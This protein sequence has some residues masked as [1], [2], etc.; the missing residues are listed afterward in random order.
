MKKSFLIAILVFTAMGFAQPQIR[1]VSPLLK[2]ILFTSGSSTEY[3]IWISF[4][5]K[6]EALNKV[7]QNEFL[8]E[9]SI[10]RR[11]KVA[12][13]G[14]L[15]DFT[16]YPVNGAYINA[17]ENTGARIKNKSK[18]LNSVSAYA[19]IN[20]IVKLSR[21][22][23]VKEMDIVAT[24]RRQ[25]LP[26]LSNENPGI[27]EEINTSLE[28]NYGSSFSQNMQ[29]NVPPV[30]DQGINGQNVLIG[31]FDAGFNRLSHESFAS[32]NIIARWDFVNHDPGVG[33]STD[34]GSGTH[35]TQ[36]LS[37]IGGYK[38]G[39]LIGP[40][41]G[42]K[43]ILA[44]TENTV[45]ETPIEEDNWMAA[46]EWA[47]S[48]GV[49]VTSTSLGYIDFDPPYTSY[50]WQ[51]MNGNTCRITIGADLAV[52][53]GIVVLNSAGNEG[54]NATRNTLGAPSDGDSVIA[55]GSVTSTSTRSSFSSVGNT[56]DGRIKPDVMARGESTTVA[57]P[58]SNTQY[59]TASGTSFSCPLAAGVAALVLCARPHLTPMQVREALRNT[60]SNAASPNREYGWG[61]LNALAAINYFAVPVE[62]TS[63][64]ANTSENSVVLSWTTASESNNSGFEIQRSTDRN[65]WI[66]A[67]FLDGA[68][69]T[70]EKHAY[71]FIDQNTVHGVSYYR[72][73]QIDYSGGINYSKV[74]SVEFS[75]PERF[76]LEQ[77]YPNPFNPGTQIVFETGISGRTSLKVFDILGREVAVLVDKE[78]APGK[79]TFQFDVSTIE[80]GLT[81]GV[82]FYKLTS[83]ESSLTR[84]MLVTK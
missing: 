76:I 73:K 30:H 19:S 55:V 44:K 53:K 48:I 26:E 68:G 17:V 28:L 82:Y 51:S 80:G 12:V 61:I 84:K 21:L 66:Q 25:P 14:Q 29:L 74:I 79:Y 37:A 11:E 20:S 60:A 47:D 59:T 62:L 64:T 23:C 77:N 75:G 7:N 32:M 41:F 35:G 6:G 50:T 63:F 38:S 69:T 10:R 8:S 18:W 72:L 40:A 9:K 4:T 58:Y 83:G 22:D 71:S 1:K 54:Y 2:D 65:N 39:Q 13:D 49:D 3:L 42:A 56:I 31:V 36:T 33:D 27:P 57:N 5:D 67:G 70:T 43:Y 16:D 81:S 45:S 15:F 52:K 46:I 24:F 78:L 34:M